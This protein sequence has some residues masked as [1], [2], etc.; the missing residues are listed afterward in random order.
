VH[1]ETSSGRVARF[2][3][4]LSELKFEATAFKF[5]FQVQRIAPRATAPHRTM[6][7]VGLRT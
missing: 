6:R 1:V 3:F 2:R 7:C 4:R 5:C